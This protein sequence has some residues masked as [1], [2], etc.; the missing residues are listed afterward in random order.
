MAKIH[1]TLNPLIWGKD[2]ILLPE[3]ES[4]VIDIVNLFAGNLE[5][6]LD[7]AD[8][9]IVGSNASYNYT[10]YSDLDVHII[11]NFEFTNVPKEILQALYNAEKN[12]FNKAY[13]ISIHGVNVELYVEDIASS[14]MSNGVYSVPSREWIKVPSKLDNVPDYNLTPIV[15]VWKSRIDDAIAH[16][17]IDFLKGLIDR[18]YMIRKNSLISDGEF[19]KGNL[20]FKE[21]RNIGYIEKLK[22]IIRE[23]M[24]QQLSLED[25]DST[26]S[27]SYLLRE[28]SLLK[29]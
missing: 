4:R 6:P 2:S 26:K 10:P 18:L 17:D 25:V 5:I 22:G 29:D 21:L 13:D 14:V 16:E 7:I 1:D 12:A 28:M 15:G 11:T 24:S 23:K 9:H 20:I 8:I 3:V 19:G 27:M